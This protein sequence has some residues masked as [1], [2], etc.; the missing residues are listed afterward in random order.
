MDNQIQLFSRIAGYTA[1]K[2]L[3][4][5]GYHIS[6]DYVQALINNANALNHSLMT[7]AIKLIN[8]TKSKEGIDMDEMT[9]RL[10][11]VINSTVANYVKKV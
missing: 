10:N 6:T 7:I 9:S 11:E 3:N 1:Q 4:N 8:K 2:H 5:K